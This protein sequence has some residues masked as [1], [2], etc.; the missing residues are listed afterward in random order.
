VRAAF[1]IAVIASVACSTEENQR[2]A[3]ERARAEAAY[4]QYRRPDL[5]IKTLGLRG[6]ERVLDVGAGD[7]YLTLP[8]ARAAGPSGQVV[9]ID[10]DQRALAKLDTRLPAE[11]WSRVETRIVPPNDPRLGDEYFD[12]IL[13]AEVDHLL[14]DRVAYFRLLRTHVARGGK[15]AVSNKRGDREALL[16]AAAE[17]GLIKIGEFDGLPAHFLI[18][19]EVAS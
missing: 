8:L 5:L 14:R 10:V 2:S 15:I 13:L 12:L 4:D 11:L 18:W 7:G 17:A 19:F 1:A 16:R 3:A 6:G 9:A